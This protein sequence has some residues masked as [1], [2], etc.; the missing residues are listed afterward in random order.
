MLFRNGHYRYVCISQMNRTNNTL[1]VSPAPSSTSPARLNL[2]N[3]SRLCR[4][5]G[6]YIL[7]YPCGMLFILNN[8]KN[9]EIFNLLE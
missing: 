3:D 7:F 5:C 9:H 1:R 4:V 8:I 6:L 2:M